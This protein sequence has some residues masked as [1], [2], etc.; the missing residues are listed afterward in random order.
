MIARPFPQPLNGREPDRE[1]WQLLRNELGRL[2]GIAIFG[3]LK[4]VGGKLVDADG[5]LAEYEVARTH[6]SFLLPIGATGGAA[7]IIAKKLIGSSA[8]QLK[9]LRCPSKTELNQ[10]S[11]KRKSPAE[12]VRLAMSIIKKTASL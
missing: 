10:L 4:I 7:S 1:Q 9:K 3:G 2:S 5:V 12:L 11:D 6:G 8:T